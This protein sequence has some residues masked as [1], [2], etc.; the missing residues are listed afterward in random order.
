MFPAFHSLVY[1]MIPYK[2]SNAGRKRHSIIFL[3]PVKLMFRV[4]T[5][6]KFK[7]TCWGASNSEFCPPYL[8]IR[9]F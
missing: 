2:M 8:P 7:N 9:Y 5:S 4:S 6:R 1:V 3:V